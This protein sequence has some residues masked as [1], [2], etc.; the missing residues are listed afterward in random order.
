MKLTLNT[1]VICSVIKRKAISDDLCCILSQQLLQCENIQ[2]YKTKYLY[3]WPTWI[4]RLTLDIQLAIG[5]SQQRHIRDLHNGG[6]GFRGKA[7]VGDLRDEEAEAF[8]Q[9]N[10]YNFDVLEKIMGKTYILLFI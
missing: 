4:T 9:T 3:T 6:V 5:T 10:T 7:L 1:N 2:K 8:L